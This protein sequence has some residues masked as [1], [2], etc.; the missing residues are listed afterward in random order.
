MTGDKVEGFTN[1]ATFVV[2]V[3]ADNDQAEQARMVD[4]VREAAAAHDPARDLECETAEALKEWADQCH[5]GDIGEPWSDLLTAGL[6]EV[7]W[8]DLAR[9]YM[10]TATEIGGV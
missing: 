10:R 4:R 8:L 6:A 2:A 3:W 9:H 7:D 5:P 1:Y